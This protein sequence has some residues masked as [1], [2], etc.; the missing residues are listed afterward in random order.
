[1]TIKER[2]E[3]KF[4]IEKAEICIRC[5]QIYYRKTGKLNW[6]VC[7]TCGSELKSLMKHYKKYGLYAVRMRKRSLYNQ[8][9]KDGKEEK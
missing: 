6:F 2:I 7:K 8:G 9:Y 1:M 4:V 5:E 3:D